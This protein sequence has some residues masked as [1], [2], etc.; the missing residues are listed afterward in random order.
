MAKD[1]YNLDLSLVTFSDYNIPNM[2]L[3]DGKL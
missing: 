2:A 3:N 1:K